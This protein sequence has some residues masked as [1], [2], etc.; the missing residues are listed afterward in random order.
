MV[1]LG[2]TYTPVM[3]ALKR[4]LPAGG[5]LRDFD[6]RRPLSEQVADVDVLIIGSHRVTA[7]VIEAAPKLRLLQQHGRGVDSV[8]LSGARRRGVQVANV[9]GGNGVAVAELCLTLLL[10]LAKRVA[11]MPAAVSARVTGAPAGIEIAGK[12]LAIVGLGNAGTGLALRANALG[13]TVLGVRAR[14][15]AG[16]PRGVQQVFGPTQLREVLAQ[17]D[18]VCLLATLTEQTRGMIGAGE[19]HSMKPSAYVVNAARGAIVDYEALLDALRGGRIAGA[20]FDTFWTE[21]ADPADPILKEPNFF[22][23][24]HVAGFSDVSIDFVTNAMAENVRRLL[25]GRE[26][27][28]AVSP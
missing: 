19:L 8:D 28:N 20:A 11:E 18:F 9:P 12:K 7:D 24:P 13:M 27:L 1:I 21:P 10:L 16:T 2:S 5:E 15:D 22:L 14:P 4:K 3:D 23:S 25:D 17:A 6:P 26:L